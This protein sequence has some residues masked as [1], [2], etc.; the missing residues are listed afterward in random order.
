M[1]IE[2]PIQISNNPRIIFTRGGVP[3]TN[4]VKANTILSVLKTYNVAVALQSDT[5]DLIVSVLDT[6]TNSQDIIINN[7]PIQTPF[8]LGIVLMNTA[9]EVYLNNKLVNTKTLLVPP[10]SVTGDIIPSST[11]VKMK[12]LKIWKRVL[13]TSEIIHATPNTTSASDFGAGPIP[14]S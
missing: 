8:R 3:M 2:N 11:L 10:K 12:N 6:N 9:L 13:S 4:S 14:S 5:T 7:I 1:F